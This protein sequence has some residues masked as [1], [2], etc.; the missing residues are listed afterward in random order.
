MPQELIQRVSCAFWIELKFGC[1]G[2]CGEGKTGDCR[3]KPLGSI[4]QESNP[5]HTGGRQVL[6][7]LCHP[8]SLA[9]SQASIKC[10]TLK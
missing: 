3:E 10:T 6:S 7:P 5:S 2:F 9:R 1:V 4:E 8:C